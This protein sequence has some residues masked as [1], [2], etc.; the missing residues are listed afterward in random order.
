MAPAC[1]LPSSCIAMAYPRRATTGAC[2]SMS[3]G[4]PKAL[5]GEPPSTRSCTVKAKAPRF[6][7]VSMGGCMTSRACLRGTVSNFWKA[8]SPFLGGLLTARQRGNARARS[9]RKSKNGLFD[10]LESCA[11][12]RERDSHGYRNG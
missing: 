4:T 12:I 10:A 6:G 3:A 8:G 11:V 2:W 9:L 1:T 5:F 7:R